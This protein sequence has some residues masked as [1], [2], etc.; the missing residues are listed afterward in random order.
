SEASTH[1]LERSAVSVS[2]PVMNSLVSEIASRFGVIVSERFAASAVP[3]LGAVG[4]ATVN[5]IFMNHFQRIAQAH[6]TIRRLERRYGQALVRHQYER[7]SSQPAE[8]GT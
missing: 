6:F 1:L 4:G 2:T 5:L 3:V 8:A 7:L